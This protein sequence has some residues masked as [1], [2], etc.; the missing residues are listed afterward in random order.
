[1]KFK[2]SFSCKAVS[3]HSVQVQRLGTKCT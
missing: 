3:L 1:M 2:F